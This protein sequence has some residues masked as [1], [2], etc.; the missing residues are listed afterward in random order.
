MKEAITMNKSMNI[1]VLL[2][3][4]SLSAQ[5]TLA[6]QRGQANVAYAGDS[7]GYLVKNSS[8]ECVRTSSWARELA[9]EE[10]DPALFP[11]KV[12]QPAPAPAPEPK[13][14]PVVQ[15]MPKPETVVEKVTLSAGALFDVSKAD[16]KPQGKKELDALVDKISSEKLGVAQITVTGH[17][18]STGA[19]AYNQGLSEHRAEAVKAYLVQ[20]GL[21]GERIVT[22]GMGDSQ[23]V[24][25]NKTAAG[26]AQNRRVE[27][28]IQGERTGTSAN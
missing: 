2:A 14:A 22:K 6:Q 23:P 10:C 5:S 21:I 25:S 8:G 16:L 24:A 28:D 19:K 13:P 26:R 27:I 12:A 20:K 18:D 1:A 7:S 11:K 3:V 17:T 4:V 9:L 15:P